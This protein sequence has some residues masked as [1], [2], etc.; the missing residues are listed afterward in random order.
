MESD[1]SM[2]S[3]L[4]VSQDDKYV[5]L[6]IKLF[7]FFVLGMG[8]SWLFAS[9]IFQEVPYFQN[10]QPE[11]LCIAA[12][13]SASVNT[14]AILAIGYV[15]I[16]QCFGLGTP[17]N[18]I[19]PTL[20]ILPCAGS[21]F[22]A[23]FF[24][25]T[26]YSISLFI[27]LT[28]FF[29]GVVGS[30]SAMVMNPFMSGFDKNFISSFR[31]GNSGGLL[32]VSLVA[33]IQ[34]PGS[35]HMLFSPTVY[36]SLF[37]TILLLPI[38]M[39]RFLMYTDNDGDESFVSRVASM[40]STPSMSMYDEIESTAGDTTPTS[41]NAQRN[42]LLGTWVLSHKVT[43]SSKTHSAHQAARSSVAVQ[44]NTKRIKRY[45][46]AGFMAIIGWTNFNTWGMLPA[47]LPF[48]IQAAV[49]KSS[50]SLYL[51]LAYCLG[52]LSLACGD[53]STMYFRLPFALN[54]F[55]FTLLLIVIYGLNFHIHRHLGIEP[56]PALGKSYGS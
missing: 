43:V 22:I 15:F 24:S 7:K 2:S 49:G 31:A 3:P 54:M 19:I 4:V 47:L 34:N 11:G 55:I 14:G 5:K 13:M 23:Y 10:K 50:G 48:A 35:D 16:L 1:E 29:S 6:G 52:G 36:Y 44:S 40:S 33:L 26:V 28:C 17:S 53:L 41:A 56:S 45:Y 8:P 12:Y 18:Y 38:L 32:L 46:T 27:Y 9:I 39:Y 51:N 25:Y 42:Y 30:L 21:I 37:A 20:L